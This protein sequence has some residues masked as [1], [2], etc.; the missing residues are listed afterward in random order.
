MEK[1]EEAGLLSRNSLLADLPAAL[2]LFAREDEPD[3]EVGE[4]EAAIGE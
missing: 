1:L 4:M 3:E 2:G